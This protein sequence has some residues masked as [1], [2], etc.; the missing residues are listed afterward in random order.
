[1]II[2]GNINIFRTEFIA[3]ELRISLKRS[4]NAKMGTTR[5]PS[6]LYKGIKQKA[7]LRK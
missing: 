4:S 2:C 5:A 1:M 7:K 3:K 6:F